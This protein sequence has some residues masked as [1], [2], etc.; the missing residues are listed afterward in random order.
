MRR[1]MWC[2]AADYK[3]DFTMGWMIMPFQRYFDFQGRSR[4]MEFWMFV[5]LNIIVGGVLAGPF[6]FSLMTATLDAAA[7]GASEDAAFA[8]AFG[9][10]G[11]LSTL[12][13]GLFGLW[14][15]AALIP[16]IAVTVRR[17]HDRDM[18]G[19][20]YLGV[21]VA[22]FIPFIGILTSLAFL[23]LMFLPGTDGPNRFGPD[24][25]KPFDEEVFS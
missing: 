14:W 13:F 24:P 10:M 3:G 2:F 25:K 16:G 8:A 5:L 23:V 9:E 18:S 1:G 6:Y 19:W 20:W 21:I 17:L 12:C 4:R 15:L 22:S 11:T 7:S